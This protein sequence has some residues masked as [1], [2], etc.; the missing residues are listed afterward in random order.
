MHLQ[1]D[2]P[3]YDMSVKETFSVRH[4]LSMLKIDLEKITKKEIIQKIN[5]LYSL[6]RIIIRKIQINTS[7]VKRKNI[8]LGVIFD[9]PDI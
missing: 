5:Y 9:R 7:F 8:R 1:T 3:V 2:L 6:D 4:F